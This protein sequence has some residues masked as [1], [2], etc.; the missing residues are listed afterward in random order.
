DINKRAIENLIKAGA[1]DGLDGNRR[2]ML[3]VYTRILDNVNSDRK[4][5]IDGQMSFLDF[6][7]D[8]T[9]KQFEIALP[10][11]PEYEKETLLEFEKEA[12]NI[13]VSGHPLEEYQDIMNANVTNVTSDLALDEST[14]ECRVEDDSHI[15][16]GGMITGITIKYTKNNKTMAFITVEDLVGQAEVI[17]F[18]N[19][20]DTCQYLLREDNKVLIRGRV[21]ASDDNDAK[22]ICEGMKG[23]DEVNK[24]AWVIFDSKESF[25][26]NENN[27]YKVL[28]KSTGDDNV[29]IYIKEGHLTKG[30]GNRYNISIGDEIINTLKKTF[31]DDRIKVQSA[32][33]KFDSIRRNRY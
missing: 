14:G 23:F 24:V 31:G 27:L 21:N 2:Q 8:D 7:N 29:W 5:S 30:L 10:N 16:I 33:V 17:V 11:L 28:D 18:P 19:I 9:K 4:K 22:L 25:E 26:E 15:T 12:L 13:Y 6:A 20:Y 1:L 32:K 3:S